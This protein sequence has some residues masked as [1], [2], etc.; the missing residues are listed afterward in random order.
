VAA[1]GLL[2]LAVVLAAAGPPALR[3]V[4]VLI[5]IAAVAG[6]ALARWRRR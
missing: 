3:E 4:H 6:A 5:A 1:G 2:A